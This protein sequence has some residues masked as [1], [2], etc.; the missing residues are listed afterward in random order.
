M[1]NLR[2]DC[3]FVAGAILLTCLEEVEATTQ[4]ILRLDH[5][6]D[7]GGNLTL[8]AGALTLACL[9]QMD[10]PTERIRRLDQAGNLGG[11]LALMAGA[12]TLARFQEVDAPAERIRRF[13]QAGNL[14]GNLALMAGALSFACLQQMDAPTDMIGCVD[15]TV[16]AHRDFNQP[17]GLV[18]ALRIDKLNA[19]CQPINALAQC[20]Q[21]RIDIAKD[22]RRLVGLG[23]AVFRLALHLILQVNVGIA[24]GKQFGTCCADGILEAW[25]A[26]Q[27][28]FDGIEPVSGFAHLHGLFLEHSQG[29]GH[30]LGQARQLGVVAAALFVQPGNTL[31]GRSHVHR[32]LRC[33]RHCVALPGCILPFTLC[34]CNHCWRC[35][36]IAAGA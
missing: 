31:G 35:G 33:N 16:Y 5:R 12:L 2:N 6:S 24:Q 18:F 28:R 26:C 20:L 30:L 22:A 10:A 14:G 9:Q 23:L 32:F 3:S 29:A 7:L 27:S 25:Y 15:K 17:L 21:T 11:N 8:V 36:I 1:G 34:N 13:D 4:S 19:V